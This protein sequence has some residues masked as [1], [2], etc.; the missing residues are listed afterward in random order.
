L[1]AA[2]PSTPGAPDSVVMPPERGPDNDQ[3][4]AL[5][6]ALVRRSKWTLITV[7]VVLCAVALPVIWLSVEPTYRATASVHVAPVVS[8]IVFK[9]EENAS[10][11]PMLYSSYLNTQK[12]LL[13]STP[14][15]ERVLDNPAVQATGW[16]QN[17]PVTWKTK[18]GATP[19]TH[20]ERLTDA[21]LVRIQ[22]FG[23]IISVSMIDRSGKDATDIVNVLVDEYKEFMDSQ[24]RETDV[25]RFETLTL[26]RAAL[27]KEIDGLLATKFNLAKRLG[28][29]APEDLRSQLAMQLSELE[30]EREDL[31]HAYEM[32][33]WE[34]KRHGGP[35]SEPGSGSASGEPGEMTADQWNAADE[36]WTE[37]SRA[38]ADVRHELET[39]RS[40]YGKLH[41]RIRSLEAKLEHAEELLSQREAQL[42]AMRSSG[43]GPVD[44]GSED[45]T[46]VRDRATLTVLADRQKHELELL[47]D[48][49][50]RQRD[51]VAE[52][53][54]IARDIAQQEEEIA[55]K[56]ELYEA[57][58]SRLQVLE[59]E[60]KAPARISVAAYAVAPTRP[61]RDRRPT[62][63]VMAMGGS[64]MIGLAVVFLRNRMDP[65][66][67]EADDVRY[68][69]HVPFL[70]Q[71]PYDPSHRRGWNDADATAMECV[72]MIRT[73]LLERV[74]GTGS[75]VVL[76]TSSNSRA[77]KTSVALALARSL[78]DL[79]KKTLLVE[80][81]L[82][83]P[84]LHE[85]LGLQD[86]AGLAALLTKSARDSEVML[87][88]GDRK[89]D[90]ILAGE[91]PPGFDPE[92]LADGVF[93]ACLTRWRKSYDFVLLDS[94]P[95]LPVADARILARQADG[96]IMILRASHCRR[97]EVLQAQADLGAVG[98]R[99]LGT[100][101]VGGTAGSQYGYGAEY[102]TTSHE[103]RALEVKSAA[104]EED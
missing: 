77:G 83:R 18:I 7:I 48:Q 97:T 90:I 26:E 102:A 36:E 46:P 8:R 29:I 44:R 98:C 9:T 47:D 42:A 88:T 75:R 82:R 60:A 87:R 32:T 15:L 86:N 17:P 58:R 104:V 59:L 2:Q 91:L 99:L 74:R 84:T 49:I 27:R 68:A 103:V 40:R 56:R 31:H 92:L 39:A 52:A 71:V 66:I 6:L 67:Y 23:E 53:G 19:P 1:A 80:A 43:M 101:L 34:L 20:L 69:V 62:L 61:N 22:D 72:R 33:K 28:T 51:R 63:S 64:F 50:R 93:A 14:V 65:K 21:L 76:I 78:A 55:H 10:G 41:P 13:Q 45:G 4:T 73:A 30:A 81:D 3:A 54:D 100:V 79:G 5:S 12:E 16:Y 35:E 57:V 38:V 95:V 24:L 37:L 96:T 70:G 94:P 11:V 85:R 89:P 25:H